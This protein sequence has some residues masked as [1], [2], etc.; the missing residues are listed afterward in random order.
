MKRLV[1]AILAVLAFGLAASA[2]GGKD[3]YNKY[4]GKQGVSSVYISPAM[5]KLVKSL[6]EVEMGDEDMN[7]TN[8]VKSLDGMYII[9]VENPSLAS[10]LARDVERY[11]ASRKYE[12]LMEAIDEGEKMQIFIVQKNN[13]VSDFVLYAN[14]GDEVSFISIT[15]VMPLEEI[16][17]MVQQ[18]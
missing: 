9:D 16:S 12:K 6:P 8:I 10:E 2:Q 15:G 5:F 14:E 17:K 3:I 13:V 11:V 4:S 18:M 7:M 1:I